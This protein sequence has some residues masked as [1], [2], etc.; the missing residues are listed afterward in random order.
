MI[1]P[2]NKLYLKETEGKG[3]GVFASDTIAKGEVIEVCHITF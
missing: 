1:F 2:P 3:M